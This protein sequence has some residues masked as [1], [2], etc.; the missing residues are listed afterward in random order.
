[1]AQPRCYFELIVDP[2]AAP[3]FSLQVGTAIGRHGPE[4]ARG[5]VVLP[6][7]PWRVD[8][9]CVPEIMNVLTG[10]LA[11]LR[12]ALRAAGVPAPVIRAVS[13]ASQPFPKDR[14]YTPQTDKVWSEAVTR[15]AARTV[16]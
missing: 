11:A 8:N 2:A 12:A 9:S 1:M 7:S 10:L 16:T 3:H 13:S 5:A 15:A 14:H 4:W 6:E